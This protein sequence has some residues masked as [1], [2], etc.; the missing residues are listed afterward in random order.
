MSAFGTSPLVSVGADPSGDALPDID[1]G[2]FWP[3]IKLG[4]ARAAM[5]LD[6]TVTETRLRAALVE[7][8]ITVIEALAA[9]KIARL[10][11]GIDHIDKTGEVFDGK[12]RHTHRWLRAVHCYAAASLA[13]R[14]R[15][16]DT[17]KPGAQHA[18][19]VESPIDDLRRD[20]YWAIADILGRSRSVVELI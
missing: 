8:A 5:R 13:E 18:E 1:A 6:G 10:A 9:W 4:E 7:A 11:E 12:S 20:G 14:Y 19:L 3:E 2:P 16:I 15:G 17:T